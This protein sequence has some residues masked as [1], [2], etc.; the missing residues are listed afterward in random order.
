LKERRVR[1][2]E[3]EVGEVTVSICVGGCNHLLDVLSLSQ[4]LVQVV[5]TDEP[6]LVL[7]EQ[8]SS[9]ISEKSGVRVL[10]TDQSL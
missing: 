3:G 1:E 7:R 9:E 10:S 2:G 8:Q 5:G 4:S 6:V